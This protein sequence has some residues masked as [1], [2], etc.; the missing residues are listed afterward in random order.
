M[1]KRLEIKKGDRYGRLTIIK[2]VSKR[3]NTRWFLCACDCGTVKPFCLAAMRRK[4]NPSM[5]CGCYKDE[6]FITRNTSHRLSR[7]PIYNVW[8]AMIQRCTNPK[9]KSF[10]NYG[11]RGITVC[12]DW[13]SFSCFCK[14]AFNSGYKKNLTID[15][16]NND[17]NYEPLNCKWSTDAE[18]SRNNRKTIK[19]TFNGVT[20]CLKDWADKIGIC[21]TSLKKRLK[22]WPIEKALAEPPSEKNQYYGAKSIGVQ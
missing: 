4:D 22:K 20:L 12:Q 6:I 17:G 21:S 3:N 8:Q 11:A 15:R 14:W 19:I 2:E 13:F 7:S 10:N 1:A 5:S 16:I 18:Q 9:N